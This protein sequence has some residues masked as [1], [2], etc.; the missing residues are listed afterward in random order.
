MNKFKISQ[1]QFQ[2]AD[3]P[4]LNA[5][6]LK[7]YFLKTKIFKPDLICTPECSNIITNDKKYLFNQSTFQKDCPLIFEAK[8]FAKL[9]S[10]NIHLGSLLLK[11]EGKKKLVNR[12]LLIDREGKIKA[13]YDKIHLFDVDIDKVETHRESNSFLKGTKMVIS[14]ISGVKVGFTIC[15]DLRFP[16]LYRQLAKKGAQIILIPAA[17]TV[18]TGIAHWETLIRARAIENSVFISATNMCGIHHSGRKTYG[19]SIFCDPWG[20]IVNKCSTKPKILNTIINLD[21]IEKV[22]KKT[23]DRFSKR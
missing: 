22:R 3:T 5:Q 19:Y 6:L 16:L 15:Y 17:F 9:H 12:S 11:I 18:P 13:S 8:E 4:N 21:M 10:V 14:S 20:K 1:I 7:K 23:M 2:A